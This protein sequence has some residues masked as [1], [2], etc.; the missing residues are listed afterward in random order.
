MREQVPAPPDSQKFNQTVWEIVRQIPPGK[1][2][3]YG[4]IAAMIPAQEGVDP[5]EYKAWRARWVGSAMSAS[6]ADVP[7][8]RVIN[9]QGKISPR[10]PGAERQR[11]LLEAEGVGFDD[12]GRVDLGRFGWLGPSLDWLV[13][14][15]L[16]GDSPDPQQRLL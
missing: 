7:W 1:V 2:A 16:L 6:P 3:T 10:G 14:Q 8:Q 4:Q 9:A 15:G 11:D 5:A 13:G 12:R